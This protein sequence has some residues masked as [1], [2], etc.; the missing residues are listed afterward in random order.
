MH[1]ATLVGVQSHPPV[2]AML[3]ITPPL[4][5]RSSATRVVVHGNVALGFAWRDGVADPRRRRMAAPA[6][7]RF[8]LKQLPLTYRAAANE[9][10][11]RSELTVRVGDVAWAE[12]PTLFG[13]AP[14]ERA[15]TLD[16][17]E[18]GRNFVVFGDGVRGARLPSGVNNVRA[19]YRKGLGKDGNVA[20][21]KL[22]Q[23]MHAAARPEER[24]QSARRPQ[25]GTDPGAG[26]AGAA[27]ACRS[28]T[29]TLGRAVSLLDYE[30]FARALQR[31]RQGAGAGAAA[32]R[33]PDHCDHHCRTG[34]CRRSPPASP[35]WI[36]LLGALTPE[37]RSA[38]RRACCSRSRA[39]HVPS[40]P[41]GEARPGLRGKGGARRGRGGIARAVSLSTHARS[42]QPVQ[43]SDVIAVAQ[44]VPGVVAV[45]LDAL[46]GGTATAA[47]TSESQSDA[48]ARLAHAREAGVARAGRTAHARIRIRSTSWRRWHELADR[49]SPLCAAAGGL[50]RAR[51]AAGRAAARAAR[52]ASPQEFAALEENVE[53]L[54]DDQFIETCA[55]WVAPYIGDLIGYRPLHGVAPTVA[56]PRAEVANTIALSPAQGHGADARAAGARR[57]RLAGAR[58]RVL[59][60][61]R[62]HAIHEPRPA[63]RAGHRG[64]ALHAG[65]CSSR[66][67]RSTPSRTPPRCAGRRAAPGA[68]TFR[69]S[70][71]SCGGCSRC[72]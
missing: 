25:G 39:Q 46:Y 38:C 45:D 59:R 14:T 23:L 68:T 3:T 72:G 67:A 17:D 33:R 16:V 32:A 48:A 11:A 49:R 47:Q 64:P 60:A 70:A 57:H 63:A 34:R 19:T 52:R 24:Q 21:D 26:K 28:S 6:F 30:D 58:G 31:H 12:R 53:Q 5:Q 20:A 1:E 55:D 61:A 18:Q 8:E 13:A 41:Q 69:T 62:H 9:T 7:Q 40:R 29:R 35:V 42:G 4:P 65:A 66:A 50:P 2:G 54:Y 15:Y 37:R 10:G 36:N 51:R 22:T 71:S 56:S 43:Q 44:A 27:D